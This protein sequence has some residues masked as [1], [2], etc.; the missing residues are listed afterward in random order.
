MIRVSES[1]PVPEISVESEC[2]IVGLL[3]YCEAVTLV[4]IVANKT[5]CLVLSVN[6]G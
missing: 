6:G 5:D 1:G 2:L 3:L 4:L